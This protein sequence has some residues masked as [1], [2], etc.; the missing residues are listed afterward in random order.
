MTKISAVL[1]PLAVCLL[2]V[3]GCAPAQEVDRP[4]GTA[5]GIGDLPSFLPTPTSNGVARGSADS[6]AM[7]YPGSPVIV[8]LATGS[9]TVDVQ[10]PA[11]PPDT[12]LNAVQVVGTFTITLRDSDTTVSLDA[13]QFDVLDHTGGV[14]ELAAAPSTTVPKQV[15]PHQTATLTLSA[16][17]PSGEGLLRYHPVGGVVVAAWDYVAETD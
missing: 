16:T 2:L 4:I 15:A 6:P 17:L 8:Q 9:V 11:L 3:A 10:G 14:H 5:S 7:S 13:S 12:K 1:T